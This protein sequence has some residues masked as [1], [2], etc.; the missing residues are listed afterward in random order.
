MAVVGEA[1][2]LHPAVQSGP[3]D[4]EGVDDLSSG[5]EGFGQRC[6]L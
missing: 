1:L 4:V 6:G 5:Q 2:V 3:G